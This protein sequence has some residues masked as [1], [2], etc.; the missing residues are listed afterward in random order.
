M[1]HLFLVF[2]FLT[3]V[4]IAIADE[5]RITTLFKSENGEY[6]LQLNKKT[7]VLKNKK[8][9]K[10]YSI[11]NSGY[12]SMSILVSNDGQKL[13]VIDDFMEGHR[14]GERNALI[15]FY[16]GKLTKSHKMI[17]LVKDT[18]NVT[19]TIWHT[20]WQ[21]NDF[22]FSKSDSTF[23]IAT[24][25][26]NEIEFNTFDGS[27]IKNKKSFPT[28][29]S[30]LIVAAEF[31]KGSSEQCTL[32]IRKYIFGKKE[33]NDVITIK[34]NYYGEGHWDEVLVIKEGVDVTPL[35]Y[36]NQHISISCTNE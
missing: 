5:Q 24:F 4:T 25:E 21:L 16:K 7:W 10:I 28:D 20:I 27:I 30:T 15:F 12:E 29:D 19:L 31:N 9:K 13:V 11:L 32:H 17:E 8:G 6:S 35:R 34:T 33:P 14:I 3:S 26:F 23:V 36:R 22:A 2:L 18:C 1:R